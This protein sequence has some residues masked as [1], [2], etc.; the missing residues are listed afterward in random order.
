MIDLDLSR[1]RVDLNLIKTKYVLL[2]F[3][4]HGIRLV[5]VSGWFWKNSQARVSHE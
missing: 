4:K 2:Y 1:Q 5:K 3:K